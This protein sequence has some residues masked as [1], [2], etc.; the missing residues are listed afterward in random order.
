MPFPQ[1]ALAA[2]LLSLFV[3]MAATQ[4]LEL[5]S[6]NVTVSIEAGLSTTVVSFVVI[7][8]RNCST[9]ANYPLLIPLDARYA[10]QLLPRGHLGL[11]RLCRL[12]ALL[13]LCVCVCVCVCV[14]P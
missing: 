3:A 9:T 6:V 13:L 7:N 12:L 10:S 5:K 8:T 2:A 4:E 11:G 1:C 14:K